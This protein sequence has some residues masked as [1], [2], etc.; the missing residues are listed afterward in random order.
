MMFAPD[1]D[2]ADPAPTTEQQ[3]SSYKD[4]QEDAPWKDINC[5]LTP[6]SLLGGLTSKYIRQGPLTGEETDIKSYDSGNMYVCSVDGVDSTHWGKLWVEY[7]VS[8][9][10]PQLQN[11]A[12]ATNP[13]LRFDS[14]GTIS[15]TSPFGDAPVIDGNNTSIVA[16]GGMLTF[17][18]PGGYIIEMFVVG[19]VIASSPTVTGTATAVEYAGNINGAATVQIVSYIIDVTAPGQTV[20]FNWTGHATTVT[21]V[22]AIV[23][24]GVYSILNS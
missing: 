20:I 8:L 6:K 7:D 9:M 14:G 24:A 23:T 13:T 5:V 16:V 3:A 19:T 17:P 1:Y 2:A 15:L 11:A 18:V 10:T 12:G 21:S 22:N 4:C